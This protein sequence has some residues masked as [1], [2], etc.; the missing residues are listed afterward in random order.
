MKQKILVEEYNTFNDVLKSKHAQYMSEVIYYYAC[1]IKDREQTITEVVSL[2]KGILRIHGHYDELNEF[3]IRIAARKLVIQDI[4]TMNMENQGEKLF[5]HEHS[6]YVI[7]DSNKSVEKSN[8]KTY[9]DLYTGIVTLIEEKDHFQLFIENCSNIFSKK[10]DNTIIDQVPLGKQS[11]SLPLSGYIDEK[12][13]RILELFK[14]NL[15]TIDNLE[16]GELIVKTSFFDKGHRMR[17]DPELILKLTKQ[18][19]IATLIEE[20]KEQDEDIT[21]SIGYQLNK[22]QDDIKS[23]NKNI[24]SLS[25]KSLEVN[26][27]LTRINLLFKEYVLEEK[28]EIHDNPHNLLIENIGSEHEIVVVGDSNEY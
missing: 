6:P 2:N 5:F 11:E 24:N 12:F 27:D 13:P 22:L 16:K 19:S 3:K 9:V 14:D 10:K 1:V 17:L 7:A 15:I 28:E 8:L 4:E 20:S 18:K 21:H 26:K 25:E 23:L